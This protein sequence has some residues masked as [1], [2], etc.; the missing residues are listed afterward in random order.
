MIRAFFAVPADPCWVESA[1]DLLR[2]LRA[3]L[4]EASWTRPES[5]HLTLH[6]L[7]EIS[8]SEGDR[9][10]R[11]IAR[12]AGQAPE[13]ELRASGAVVFPKRGPARV[14]GVG[15]DPSPFTESLGRLAGAA[16]RLAPATRDS[17]SEARSFHPHV[18]FARIR[19]SWPPQAVERYRSA[20]E[21]WQA[22]TWRARSCVLYRSRLD[23][24]GAVHTPIQTWA[25]GPAPMPAEARR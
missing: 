3:E 7:G 22:P 8:A 16:A 13:G 20:M 19:R 4:P 9:F 21:Q 14:L 10:S 1:R 12:L 6:F 2:A 18:T 11:D 23:P 5:W 15:F 17:K 25:L 24:A